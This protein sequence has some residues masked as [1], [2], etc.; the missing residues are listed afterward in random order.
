MKDIVSCHYKYCKQFLFFLC[1]Y[2]SIQSHSSP[3]HFLC[4]YYKLQSQK[5]YIDNSFQY[6]YIDHIFGWQV[7]F[8]NLVLWEYVL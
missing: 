3:S 5:P 1:I 7:Q 4:N 6:R 2:N 8:Q